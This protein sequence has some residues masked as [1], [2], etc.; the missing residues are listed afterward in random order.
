MQFSLDRKRRSH[1]QN[2]CSASDSV[3]LIF[4]RSYRFTLLITTPT[5]TPSLVKTSL[6][7]HL[8]TQ[9]LSRKVEGW[10]H[11]TTMSN[12]ISALGDELDIINSG[13]KNMTRAHAQFRH[14]D[15]VENAKD[16]Y[17]KT[18][19]VTEHLMNELEQWLCSTPVSYKDNQWGFSSL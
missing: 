16:E 17:V 4:T 15:E 12:M 3:G 13:F 14:E 10:R 8:Q 11:E 1:K 18:L 9:A 2:Q 6:K 5:T 7:R 19:E